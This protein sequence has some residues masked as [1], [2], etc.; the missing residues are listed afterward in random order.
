[1]KLHFVAIS[2][3]GLVLGAQAG[4]VDLT[5][6]TFDSEVLE[7]GKAAFVKFFAPWYVPGNPAARAFYS[8]AQ[9]ASYRMHRPQKRSKG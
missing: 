2:L 4:A 9:L 1:M 3:A 5:A 8:N 7:S 6:N